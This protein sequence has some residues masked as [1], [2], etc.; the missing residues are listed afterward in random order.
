MVCVLWVI[1]NNEGVAANFYK[2]LLFVVCRYASPVSVSIQNA[3]LWV[4]FCMACCFL[5]CHK[6]EAMFFYENFGLFD[7]AF[8][9]FGA[10]IGNYFV[11]AKWV[12]EFYVL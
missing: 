7:A 3:C 12:C 10:M 4:V 1:E 2:A 11:S 9:G 5:Q 8:R 6:S